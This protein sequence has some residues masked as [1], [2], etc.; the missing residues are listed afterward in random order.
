MVFLIL[1]DEQ[2]AMNRVG[3]FFCAFSSPSVQEKTM[4][5]KPTS[6]AQY[7]EVVAQLTAWSDEKV[8]EDSHVHS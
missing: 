5:F 7:R 2:N 1:P 4:F 6:H 8:F 3:A